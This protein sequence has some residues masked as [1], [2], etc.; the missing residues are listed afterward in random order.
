MRLRQDEGVISPIRP[1]VPRQL[2]EPP[3][4]GQAPPRDV[5]VQ[6]FASPDPVVRRFAELRLQGA[7]SA[8][9]PYEERAALKGDELGQLRRDVNHLLELARDLEWPLKAEGPLQAL[10]GVS[11]PTPEL[12]RDAVHLVH[13][14][15]HRSTQERPAGGFLRRELEP[16]EQD[17]RWAEALADTV[18]T[19]VEGDRVE[20]RSRMMAE[21]LP[22]KGSRVELPTAPAVPSP[23]VAA[24]AA[25][26]AEDLNHYECS[27][28][29]QK[30][31]Q[32]LNDLPAE[33]AGRVLDALLDRLDLFGSDRDLGRLGT[34]L[35]HAV[36][37]RHRLPNLAPLLRSRLPRLLRFP[38]EAQARGQLAPPK[39]H[40]IPYYRCRFYTA[41]LA[42]AGD[43]VRQ[44]DVLPQL[45]RFLDRG[46]AWQREMPSAAAS[47][48]RGLAHRDP[49]WVPLLAPRVFDGMPSLCVDKEEWQFLREAVEEH[50]WVP[51]R[52][53]VEALATRLCVPPDYHEFWVEED[54][55]QSMVLF[56]ALACRHPD[57]VAG[58]TLPGR[59]GQPV[60]VARHAAERVL[61]H[62]SDSPPRL[63]VPAN[64]RG[65]LPPFHR[66]ALQDPSV[67][68]L[69]VDLALE[70]HGRAVELLASV[71]L[72]EAEAVRLQ[73]CVEDTR[74]P[75][76]ADLADRVRVFARDARSHLSRCSHYRAPQAPEGAALE[77]RRASEALQSGPAEPGEEALLASRVRTA[78]D[79]DADVLVAV[80]RLA[81]LGAA[82][83]D[84]L[85]ARLLAPREQMTPGAESALAP[86]QEKLWD[87]LL[88]DLGST[89]V[90]IA[91]RVQKA[92]LLTGR[93]AVS[94]RV[95]IEP[96]LET[97][98][99]AVGAALEPGQR[100]WGFQV[101]HEL[102]HAGADPIMEVW[103]AAMDSLEPREADLLR[104]A[105]AEIGR[106]ARWQVALLR[107]KGLP[108]PDEAGAGGVIEAEDGRVR[109]GGV[110]LDIR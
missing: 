86:W 51:D 95:G 21:F 1:A 73:A 59:D 56:A 53:R 42:L 46:T 71:P 40:G 105:A 49:S 31:R 94:E 17:Q 83:P 68:A 30:G 92:S 37:E 16:Q 90:E 41:V 5:L 72:T 15:H 13:A 27:G 6:G 22:V 84:G 80:Q 35:E 32:R 91:D 98:D 25:E 3:P 7:S 54:L 44:E 10:R 60:S 99:H 9:I 109:I 55:D 38:E 110:T 36:Q 70:G 79:W 106:G 97:W 77:I 52:G 8:D 18:L 24:L 19:W 47:M 101:Y 34:L 61:F 39:G 11:K 96:L 104:S 65:Q 23:E 48:F 26:I 82:M 66:W 28:G 50:G 29:V 88:A 58:L 75:A 20:L 14:L 89:P 76:R 67:R 43:S 57:A 108:V 102:A 69:L 63:H 107:A 87:S 2:L 62:E 78:T 85:E 12:L 100:R 81:L 103:R 93:P 45:E 33:Q 64:H 74:D 4:R